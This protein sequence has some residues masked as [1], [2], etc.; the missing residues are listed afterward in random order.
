MSLEL[1]NVTKVVGVE[2]HIY[3][4]TIKFKPSGFNVLLGATNAGK[5]TLI[6]LL[7]GF[8]KP[9][10]GQVIFDGNDVTG[11]NP[12]KRNISLVHQFFINYPHMTVYDNIASPLRVARIAQSEIHKRVH[13]TAELLQLEKFLERRPPE[14][15]GGQ[16]Q[17]TALA[18]AIVKQSKVILLDEPL[19]NLD[20]KLREELR[21]QLPNILEQRGTVVIYA[22]TEPTEALL[23]GG[24]TALL[25]EGR[26]VQFGP[27]SK[28]YHAPNNLIASRVFSDPPINFAL[29]SKCGD[30][31]Q[32]DDLVWPITGSLNS[33]KDDRYI[34]AI[35]PHH[36][37][38][39]R[40]AEFCV[41]LK[42]K[43]QI[44][45]L[46]GSE[47]IAHFTLGDRSWVSQAPGIHQYSVGEEYEF[48]FDPEQCFYF[49]ESGSHVIEEVADG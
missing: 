7:A 5:S 23:L 41:S 31:I 37:T 42:G 8:E 12:Q 6:K 20:Y 34:V 46:S 19:A 32:L 48:F 29:V 33:L 28:I 10:S 25:H 45:E 22:T 16:Q 18:R 39:N 3:Q 35:R 36:I 21:E 27:T 4:T 15:S 47:S 49:H 26:V 43:V 40:M 38:P 2:T 44:T 14:L 30:Y 11:I 17:R 24:S 9:T 1:K 13:E